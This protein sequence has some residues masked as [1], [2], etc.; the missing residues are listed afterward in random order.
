[1]QH[2]LTLPGLHRA[3][4]RAAFASLVAGLVEVVRNLEAGAT[5]DA[6]YGAELMPIRRVRGDNAVLPVE[7]DVRLGQSLEVGHEFGRDLGHGSGAPANI[8]TRPATFVSC[9]ADIGGSRCNPVFA[10]ACRH[11][12]LS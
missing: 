9:M 7:Q 12:P 2:Q 6:A 11:W 4:Q 10:S 5:D 1:M 8:L 3:R